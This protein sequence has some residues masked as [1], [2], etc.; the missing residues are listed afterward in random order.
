MVPQACV[1]VG[2]ELVHR[3]TRKGSAQVSWREIILRHH[4]STEDMEPPV[5][6]NLRVRTPQLALTTDT[7]TDT[8]IKT[9][10][11]ETTATRELLGV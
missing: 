10:E 9:R 8:H 4:L 1:R 6:A 3:C 5:E 11:N 7:G 2:Y